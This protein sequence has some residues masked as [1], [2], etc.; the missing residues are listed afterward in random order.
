MFLPEKKEHLE[1]HQTTFK[2]KKWCFVVNGKSFIWNQ[3][4]IARSHIYSLWR[5]NKEKIW[6]FLKLL[7]IRWS[8]KWPIS[9]LLRNAVKR[10]TDEQI[11]K[12]KQQDTCSSSRCTTSKHLSFTIDKNCDKYPSFCE[13]AICINKHL[14]TSEK[15]LGFFYRLTC[16][17]ENIF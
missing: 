9:L 5:S 15:S 11:V 6:P 14:H 4:I 13:Y 2:R 1:R 10:R 8:L 12:I 16:R 7:E 17:K 3:A